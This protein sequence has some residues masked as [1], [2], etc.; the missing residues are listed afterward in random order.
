MRVGYSGGGRGA[1]T[2]WL[3]HDDGVLD[4]ARPPPARTH[5]DQPVC[6]RGRPWRPTPMPTAG[7][8]AAERFAVASA[9]STVGWRFRLIDA[10]SVT[11]R[12]AGWH[13]DDLR[14]T[15][16]RTIEVPGCW[17]RQQTGDFPHYTNIV[18]PWPDTEAPYTPPKH[19]PTGLHRTTFTVPRALARAR[20][21]CCTSVVRR[22][23]PSCGATVEFVG[24]GKDSRLP[25]EF[26]LTP[27]PRRRART[28]S[29]SW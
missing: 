5:R 28:C 27:H 25:S 13:A 11:L 29:P 21:R 17:T 16:W 18:M 26:D 14:R 9:R 7:A 23:S 20:R 24:M 15:R 10:P 2:S 22:A 1:A 6:R 4:V 12:R 19:N 3:G 8:R